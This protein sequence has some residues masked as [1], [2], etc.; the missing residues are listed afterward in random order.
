MKKASIITNA[1]LGAAVIVLFIL[2]FTSK[3]VV[4]TVT[5]M[6][7]GDTSL[8]GGIV[9]INIDSLISQYDMFNDLRTEF[10]SKAQTIQNDLNKRGRTLENDVKDF[11]T[12]VQKGLITR[13]QAEAQQQQ[14]AKR[15]QELQGYIRQKQEE[16]GE[17]EQVLNRRVFDAL[18][19]YIDKMNQEKQY[20]L[21]LS[22]SGYNNT[23]IQGDKS[24]NIT[25]SVV[26]AMN[27]EYIKQR[28]K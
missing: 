21:I 3:P 27:D 20:S 4:N 15:E 1:I 10:E 12:K 28:S 19:T 5:E 22:T 25:S 14:L 2:H 11:Q 26:E 17:E 9:Y 23:V 6:P 18:Q 7:E 24:L 16:L 8:S 13:S